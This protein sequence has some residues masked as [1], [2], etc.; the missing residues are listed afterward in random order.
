MATGAETEGKGH[1]AA[2]LR[3]VQRTV[4]AARAHERI[5][6]DRKAWLAELGFSERDIEAM[7]G[8]DE[9]R[10]LLYRKLVRRGL[11]AAIRVEIPRTAARMGPAFEACTERYFDHTLPRSPYLRDVAFEFFAWLSRSSLEELAVPPYLIDLARHELVA[12]TVACAPSED[13][14]QTGVPLELDRGVRFRAAVEIVRYA[15]AVHRLH[16]ELDAHDEPKAEP[17]ALLVYRDD[18]LEIRYLELS[19]LASHIL[20][21]LRSGETLRGAVLGACE[22]LSQPVDGAVLQGTARLLEDLGQRGVLLG[23]EPS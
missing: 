16:E 3:A 5:R 14:E 7:A 8:L 23:A 2:V 13:S 20:D 12:F 21:K 18:E 1:L 15:H 6:E 10:L 11:R 19:P 4:M 9:K 22:L 17:T